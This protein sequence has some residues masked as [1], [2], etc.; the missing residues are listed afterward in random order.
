VTPRDRRVDVLIA[1][2]ENVNRPRVAAELDGLAVEY[3]GWDTV[4]RNAAVYPAVLAMAV[5]GTATVVGA[6]GLP[7]LSIL[8]EG[9]RIPLWPMGLG[10]V[11]SA[12]HLILLSALALSRARVPVLSRGWR[13]LDGFAL[14]ASTRLLAAEAV[15]L[16]AA[17]RASAAWCGEPQQA[18]A[19]AR[20]L[21][22]A[23]TAPGGGVLLDAFEVAL[24]LGG[25]RSGVEQA[26]L[27][28]LCEARRAAL[29]R[30]VAAEAARIE[31]LSLAIA[32][33]GVLTVAMAWT[34]AYSLGVSR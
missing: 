2:I 6:V 12:V 28:A 17:L 19:L 5:L 20:A 29:G 8:P 13:R 22:A 11:L 10:A 16:P 9:D 15:P 31:L 26:T 24:L 7:A 32:G 14:L 25:A 3:A 34:W 30:E 23:A 4:L 21:D 18:I 27:S 33:M 1:G